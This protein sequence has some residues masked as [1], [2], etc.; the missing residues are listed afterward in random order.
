[1]SKCSP[2][3]ADGDSRNYYFN[4]SSWGG[5]AEV[6]STKLQFRGRGREGITTMAGQGGMKV[7]AMN[8]V[9]VYTV[10]GQRQFASW[11]DPSKKRAL[12]KDDGKF[13]TRNHRSCRASAHFLM[14][15]LHG[16]KTSSFSQA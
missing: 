13:S 11:I 4:L 3:I 9:K 12:R 14:S 16:L 7:T 15:K 10:S 6:A 5:F 2:V 1:M 8:G